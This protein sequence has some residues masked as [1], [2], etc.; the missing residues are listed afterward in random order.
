MVQYT[1]DNG[2]MECV[3]EEEINYGKMVHIMKAIG[4]IIV[5][6]EKED[7]FMLIMI[8]MK[9]NGLRIMLMD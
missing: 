3:M 6:V 9:D 2:K 4:E 1:Q 7:L 8:I 5:L